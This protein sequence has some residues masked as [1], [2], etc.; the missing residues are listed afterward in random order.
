[1]FTKTSLI[2]STKFTPVENSVSM[3]TR[4]PNIVHRPLAISAL[5]THPKFLDSSIAFSC[6]L[7]LKCLTISLAATRWS[8]TLTD[9]TSCFV[10]SA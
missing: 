6:A 7:A 1:M 5:G 9:L 10:E 8:S 3:P 4:S 2:W